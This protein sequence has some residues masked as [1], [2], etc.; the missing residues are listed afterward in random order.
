MGIEEAEPEYEGV[1]S[2]TAMQLDDA[3]FTLPQSA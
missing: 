3:L 2:L 1:A